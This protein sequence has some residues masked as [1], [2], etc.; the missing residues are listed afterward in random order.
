MSFDNLQPPDFTK[1][2]HFS[3]DLQLT[4]GG[5]ANWCPMSWII[6]DQNDLQTATSYQDHL[7]DAENCIS[8]N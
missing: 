5:L 6:V 4:G 7:N 3:Y 1:R 8:S 2:L